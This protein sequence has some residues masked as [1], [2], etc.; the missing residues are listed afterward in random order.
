[1]IACNSMEVIGILN[2]KGLFNSSLDNSARYNLLRSFERSLFA[3]LNVNG[4]PQLINI[5]DLNGGFLSNPQI[6]LNLP[7][8]KKV[9]LVKVYSFV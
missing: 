5:F 9:F 1:M 4:L 2:L 7:L 6:L 3:Q 8:Y